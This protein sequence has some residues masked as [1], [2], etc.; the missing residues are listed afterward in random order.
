MMTEFW[1]RIFLLALATT[2]L[3]KLA[4]ARLSF[5]LLWL[6]SVMGWFIGFLLL[7]IISDHWRKK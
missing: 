4:G 1:W 3:A 2:G 7:V 6:L 5:V